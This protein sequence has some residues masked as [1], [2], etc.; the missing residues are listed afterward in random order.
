LLSPV[1]TDFWRA[2]FSGTRVLFQEAAFTLAVDS[3]LGSDRRVMV[4]QTSD[5]MVKAVLDPSVMQKV[6][7]SPE[8]AMP[9]SLGEAGFRRALTEAGVLLHDADYLFYYSEADLQAL[10][11]EDS[12]GDVRRLTGDD[13]AVFA[14]FE[15]SAS[16]QDLDAAYVELDH[17]AVFGAFS[18]GRLVCAAS[19]YPFWNTRI[20]DLGVLTLPAFRGHGY[21]RAVV[22][23]LCKY[24]AQQGYQPQYRSQLDN[25]AS[26]ALAKATGFT[27]FGTWEVI[28]PNSPGD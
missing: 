19:M 22:R 21:A 10:L 16:A 11:R 15:S 18:Q 28:S 14:D 25:E 24:A 23:A 26:V 8:R 5:G 13:A 12:D 9:Q 7:L 3:A 17:W 1:V 27:R 20:A 6:G 2:T 4:L